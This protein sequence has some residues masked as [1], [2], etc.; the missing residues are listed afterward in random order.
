MLVL[1][2]R[3][4]AATHV[5]NTTAGVRA[6][7]DAGA[8]GVE[9][10]VRRTAAGSLVCSHDATLERFGGPAT[11]IVEMSDAEVHAVVLPGGLHVCSVAAVL[12]AAAGRGR[13]VLEVKNLPGEPDFDAP[14]EATARLL[15]DVL[16]R[17]P[18]APAPDV[19]VS[20]FDW[21][22]LDV[23]RELAPEVPTGFLTP[24]GIRL[25]AAVDHVHESGHAEC[26]P[27]WTAVLEE[28]T[29][30]RRAHDLG[31]RVTTW[32]V[33]DAGVARA[34]AEAG[35]DAVISNDPGALLRALPA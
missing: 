5:E 30:V 28:P 27:H 23:V 2:H 8:A 13:V 34:L 26:H 1:G 9:V 32:T 12:E 18:G 31:L 16:G 35:V 29:E 10:D 6:A 25:R 19:V 17:W 15:A 14:T 11:P 22:A 21:F 4:S 7:L 20:S 24:A 3:G 33:D